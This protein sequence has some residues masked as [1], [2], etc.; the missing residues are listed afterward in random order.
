MARARESDALL[1]LSG[2]GV[3]VPQLAVA[4]EAAGLE[5]TLSFGPPYVAKPNV[6]LGG[7]GSRGLVRMC[8]DDAE[9]R[10][11]VHELLREEI[12]G[13]PVPSVVIEEAVDG[14][15]IYLAV[16]I[17]ERCGPV[18]RLAGRGGVG[19]DAADAATLAPS[20][21]APLLDSDLHALVEAAG[22]TDAALVRAVKPVAEVLWRAFVASEATLLEL[23]PIRWN[24][25]RATAVGV[26]V[27]FD[28]HCRS[29]A[30]AFWPRVD[31]GPAARLGRDLTAREA[32]VAAVSAEATGTAASSFIELGGDVA[33]LMVGG[34]A[35]LVS[36]D[37]LSEHGLTPACIADHSPGAGEARL[38]ALI[39]AGL[40]IPDVRGAIFGAVVISLADTVPYARAL[41]DAVRQA[42]LDLDDFPVVVRLAGPN[43]EEAHRLL[44]ALPGLVVLGRDVTIEEAC[45]ILASRLERLSTGQVAT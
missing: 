27:E 7:K 9:L 12:G 15:E 38:R 32:L 13:Q 41:V 44:A 25:E 34:G 10:D 23:N 40:A 6:S 45:D 35:G 18:L 29:S 5:S 17:D 26:A 4:T 1:W 14:V 11:A 22:L 36:F 19:F 42:N 28:D 31:D 39:E 2:L 30:R 37:R 20:T 3:S 24:G 33:M 43:E 8:A 16:S 21:F